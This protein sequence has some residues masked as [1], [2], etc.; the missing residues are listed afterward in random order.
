MLGS[1]RTR[2]VL[3]L[4]AGLVL[5]LPSA[6]EAH[7]LSVTR[8]RAEFLEFAYGVAYSY[9]IS[10]AP[11]VRCVRASGDPHSAV[12]DWQFVSQDAL[13]VSATLTASARALCAGRYRLYIT[14]ASTDVRRE[15]VR[16][17]A[18]RPLP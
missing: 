18:C 11:L 2:W 14:G 10:K 15:V 3:A 1:Q 12:C 13:T 16:R 6:A 7:F 17:L 9:P 8:A 5:S 4:A